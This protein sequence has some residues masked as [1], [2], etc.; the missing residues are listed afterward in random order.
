MEPVV[1]SLATRYGGRAVV[2]KVDVARETS[3]ADAYG[4]LYVP[5]FVFIENGAERERIIGAVSEAQLAAIL[6]ALL[7]SGD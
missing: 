1:E 5:T 4:I 2:G 3:L 6:D 7:A